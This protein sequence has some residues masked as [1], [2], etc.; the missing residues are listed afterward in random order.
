MKTL[1]VSKSIKYPTTH[2]I[3]ILGRREDKDAGV[4]AV[5]PSGVRRGGD[6]L[7]VEQLVDVLPDE[8]VCVEEDGAVVLGEPPAVELGEGHPELGPVHEGEGGEVV[9]VELG[10]LEDLVV[11]AFQVAPG[12]QKK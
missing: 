8:G 4:E 12:E 10:D 3:R 2:P 5:R 11:D 7:A 1:A 9:G 6:L